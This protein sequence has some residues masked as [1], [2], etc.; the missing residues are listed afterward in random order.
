MG[1]LSASADCALRDVLLALADEAY[2]FVTPT[3][4]THAR[5]LARDPT[6]RGQT[7]SD[8]FGWNLP[9][10]RDALDARLLDLLS[11]GDGLEA[12]GD[13]FASRYRVA[14]CAGHLFLHGAFPTSAPGAVFLGPDSYRFAAFLLRELRGAL[15][16][17][18][19]VDIGAGAGVG[20]LTAAACCE[21][22]KP[23]LTDLN[24]NALRLACINAA[25]AGV[26]VQAVETDTLDDVSG[27]LDVIVANPPYLADAA[28]RLYRDGGAEH[29]AHVSVKWTRAA[30]NRLA[31]GGRFLLYTGSAIVAGKDPLRDV[32]NALAKAHDCTF[33]YDE[34]DPDAWSEELQAPAY[35]DVD[36]IAIVTAIF[37]RPS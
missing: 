36:R 7:L 29:G 24:P 2:D 3:P 4:M 13:L 21:N 15:A 27:A 28:H 10:A 11:A 30:L 20:A 31:P 19:I 35:A 17:L 23:I 37:R 6:R 26:K 8:I 18:R 25:A 14:R 33:A 22:A 16:G 9:F 1:A 5:V 32:L 34:I 12:R